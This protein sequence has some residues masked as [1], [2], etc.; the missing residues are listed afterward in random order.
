MPY[1]IPYYDNKNKAIVDPRSTRMHVLQRTYFNRVVLK[2]GMQFSHEIQGYE[3]CITVARGQCDF[4]ISKT[5][6]RRAALTECTFSQIGRRRELFE[7]KPDSVYVPLHTAAQ[8]HC[9]SDEAE[10]YIAGGLATQE[11][12]TFRVSPDEVDTVQYGSDETKTHRK[13]H[14]ILGQKQEG[15]VDKLL[16]SEL[17]TVGA[18]GWSGFPP[19]K[20]HVDRMPLESD[21]EEI[22]LFKFRPSS[23]FGAQFTYANDDDFGPVYHIK[24]NSVIL[25]DNSYHPVVAAP[26][27]EMYYFT[28]LVGK[29]QRALTQYFHPDHSYQLK[30]I[31]GIMDM[32]QKFK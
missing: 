12:D 2:K 16:L 3:S 22:Y 25:L 8:C 19:H 23:G 18:G 4:F 24:D 17:F 15:K 10:L 6:E 32:I 28:I 27:Y 7:G 13:I 9:L 14:H 30:T 31:P 21:H 29:T 26:G 1:H 5:S 11:Y 20:H